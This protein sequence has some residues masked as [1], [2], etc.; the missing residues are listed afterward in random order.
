MRKPWE[1]EFE[2]SNRRFNIVWNL[3][4]G[5]IIFIFAVVICGWVGIGYV[6]VG[7]AGDISENGARGVISELWCGKKNPGCL[8]KTLDN[9][10]EGE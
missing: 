5:F 8:E 6:A 2:K 9:L 7:A 10:S 3:A 1:S 4:L